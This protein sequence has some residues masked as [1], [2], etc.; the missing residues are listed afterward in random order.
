MRTKARRLL[1]PTALLALPAVVAVAAA[2]Q[3][4]ITGPRDV[5]RQ[6]IV[7]FHGDGPE[8]SLPASVTAG[9]AMTVTVRTFGGGCTSQGP[10]RVDTVDAVVRILP[11]DI[12]TEGRNVVCPS[13]LRSFEHRADL[14][15]EEA[16]ERTVRIVGRRVGREVDEVIELDR[17]VTV[18]APEEATGRRLAGERRLR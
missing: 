4:G 18:E 9:E 8:V 17:T 14:T 11:H 1:L 10:T 6:G 13:I 12:T 5:T 2:C 3:G 15:F 7:E 16:G